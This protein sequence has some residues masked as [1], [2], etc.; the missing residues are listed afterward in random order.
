LTTI[1]AAAGGGNWS[2]TGTWVGG[3]VP[4]AANDVQLDGTSGNVT[5]DAAAVCRSLDCSGYT[6]TL[7]HNSAITLTIGDGTAGASSIALKLVSGM[8][9]T[10]GNATSSAISFISTSATVQ[11]VDFAG[12]T[13]GNVTYNASSN[14]S[15]QMTGVHNT[16]TGATVNLT[17]GTLDTNGQTCSWGLFNSSNFNTRTLTLGASAITITGGSATVWTT[18]TTTG[19]TLNANTSSITC[20][21][22]TATFSTG[23]L[24]YYDVALTGGS[25]GTLT[26]GGSFH[27]LTRTGTVQKIGQ[28]S[29]NADVTVTGTF[30]CNGNS[31]TGRMWLLS[32]TTGTARTI[33]AAAVSMSNVDLQDITGAGAASWDLSA[34]TG[35]SGDCG[36]NTNITFT[37]SAAQTWSG[38]SGG[39]WS[40]NAWSGRVPLPQDDVTISVAFSASQTITADMPRCGRSITWAGATGTPTWSMGST[41]NS[42]FG[43]ITLIAGMVISGTS[44]LSLRGRGS[45][46]LTGAG[47]QW[48][49]AVDIAGPG[50]TYTLAD[51]F[52][53]AGQLSLRNGTLDAATFNVTVLSVRD[54]GTSTRALTMGTGT[55]STTD[56]TATTVWTLNSSGLTFSGASATVAITGTSANSRTFDG[57]GVGTYG[58]LTYTLSGSTGAL[59]VTGANT[60][61]TIN[62]SD[63]SNARTL[64]LPAST[65]TTVTTFNVNGTASKLMT[66]NSSTGGTAATLSKSSGRVSCDYLSLQDSAAGG[67]AS[68]YA[69][70]NSTN[71]SGNSGWTFT[72]PPPRG[73]TLALMGV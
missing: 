14:G 29:L 19:M 21:G 70:N 23:G 69:G 40:A 59:V 9:Y 10:L 66:V 49:Q 6:G 24:T 26:G 51:A 68:F 55:W 43:S 63:A 30:A 56:T 7:T 65:T 36:G 17:K 67:G 52:S 39:N 33:T 32:G 25:V 64:T 5:I 2:A 28:F 50:G 15:W 61:G 73:G 60:F 20:S 31:I 38:T 44:T 35:K 41:A 18:A 71:V 8:T 3:V 54:V 46:T 4:T 13:S 11:T 62:F 22:T 1:V 58:T 42:V 12:K 16:G 45:H 53:S 37:T 47:Q 57:G 72:A 27:N 48:T 34:I